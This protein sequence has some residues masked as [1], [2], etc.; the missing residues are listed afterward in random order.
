MCADTFMNGNVV[1]GH[2][3]Y[4]ISKNQQVIYRCT[5]GKLVTLRF[6]SV[7]ILTLNREMDLIHF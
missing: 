2:M 4:Y 7:V 5:Y 1:C 3:I 6:C